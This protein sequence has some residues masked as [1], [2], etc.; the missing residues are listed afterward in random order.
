MDEQP[1]SIDEVIASIMRY[2]HPE[3]TISCSETPQYECPLCKDTGWTWFERDGYTFSD[4]CECMKA[5]K[6]RRLMKD[7]GLGEALE[8][9]TFEAFVTENDVQ[10]QIKKLGQEYVNAVF[11]TPKDAPGKPWMF[12]GGNPGCGKTHICTAVCGELLKGNQGVVYMQWLTEARKLKAFVNEPDFENMVARFTDC[13][14]LYI[15]DLFK[16]TWNVQPILTEADVRTAFTILNARYLQN[17]P[18]IISCEWSLKTLMECD[19][20]VFSRVYERCNGHMMVVPRDT[21]Y[22]YRLMRFNG[23]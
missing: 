11:S 18:T 19:E 20:G 8:R 7:S 3:N 9:Q 23:A 16:Q 12:I 15:D 1:R 14:V 10:Q 22:N 6:A 21:Q 4:E 17:K 13:D 5:K 2:H